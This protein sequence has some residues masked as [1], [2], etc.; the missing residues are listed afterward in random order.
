MTR[1]ASVDRRQ[2]PSQSGGG[3]S[4]PAAL[5]RISRMLFRALS[6]A[7]RALSTMPLMEMP[8]FLA[9]LNEAQLEAVT[10]PPGPMLV[11]AGAG[12]GKTRVIT[13][14]IAWLAE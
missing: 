8:R 9:D 11:L 13:R 10:H 6:V 3:T 7:P 1:S 14:R 4:S 2:R 12:S 5:P